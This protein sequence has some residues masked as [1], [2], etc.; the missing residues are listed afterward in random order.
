[1]ACANPAFLKNRINTSDSGIVRLFHGH[2]QRGCN[3]VVILVLSVDIGR[4][5]RHCTSKNA[6]RARYSTNKNVS[7]LMWIRLLLL[8]ESK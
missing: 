7:Y 4:A 5:H 6:S 3:V 1:M 8:S 2:V